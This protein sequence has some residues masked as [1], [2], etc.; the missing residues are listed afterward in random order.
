MPHQTDI[1]SF[2]AFMSLLKYTD[3]R[4]LYENNGLPKHGVDLDIKQEILN[5]W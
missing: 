4:K 3:K 5:Q 1:D 2:Y